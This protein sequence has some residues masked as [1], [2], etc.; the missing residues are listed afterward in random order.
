MVGDTETVQGEPYSIQLFDGQT[1]LFSLHEKED[2]L[3]TF[4][5]YVEQRA[6]PDVFNLVYHHYFDFD[7][8]VLLH[9]YHKMFVG[10][11]FQ[12]C[13]LGVQWD[14]FCGKMTF[15]NMYFG[16]NI[17]VNLYDTF[18]FVFCSLEKACIDL[19]LPFQKMKRPDYL[20]ERAPTKKEMPYFQEYAKADVYALWELANWILNKVREYDTPIPISLAQFASMILRKRFMEPQDRIA[21]PKSKVCQ[22]N[23]ILSYHGGKNGLYIDTPVLIKEAYSYD[24]NSAYP[25][26]MDK[27]PSFLEGSY[28]EVNDFDK[29]HVGIYCVSGMYRPC[30]YNLFFD[31]VFN[32]IQEDRVEN[33][34]VTSFELEEAIKEGIFIPSKIMGTIWNPTATRSPLKDYVQYFFKEKQ[35]NHKESSRYYIAKILM[36]ALYGKFIQTVQNEDQSVIVQVKEGKLTIENAIYKAGGLFNPFIASLITGMV[37]TKLH[38]LEH[39]Y[40]AI[41]SS[42]DSI[43][44]LR[45]ATTGPFLGDIKFEN[46][47]ACLLVRNKLLIHWRDQ[48]DPYESAKEIILEKDPEKVKDLVKKHVFKAALHGFH[49]DVKT[50]ITLWNSRGISYE[51]SRMIRLKEAL[52]DKNLGL[53][54]LTWHKFDDAQL[55]VDWSKFHEL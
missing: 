8:Q 3:K 29:N 13:P 35:S 40:N 34:C 18:R 12:I 2:V 54:P 39:R 11:K 32:P 17:K 9:D 25:W 48:I 26:A 33:L 43:L 38:K 6:E 42:T 44:T 30:R 7:S 53:K 19:K 21:F 5:R 28:E 50:L 47:G 51:F 45:E 52:K 27:L 10:N 23:S 46:K 31:H 37:R 24:I 36:N 20:G 55:N 16:E 22:A 1:Y 4:T 49:S 14:M 15:G 41:H